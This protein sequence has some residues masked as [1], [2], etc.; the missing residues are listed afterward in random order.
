MGKHN[1]S[2]ITP[3]FINK[4]T[5]DFNMQNSNTS[6]NDSEN[7][8]SLLDAVNFIQNSWKKLA[9]ASIV[10]ATLGLAGWFVLG[11]YSAV[12]VLLNNINTNTNTYGL[13]LLTWKI[14]QK[15]LPNLAA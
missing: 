7:E 3:Y 14:I 9:I 12:Y 5:E 10:G 1:P 2:T 4:P 8:I 11:S 15:S 6:G 13:D